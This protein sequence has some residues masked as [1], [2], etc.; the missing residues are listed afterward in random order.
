M[1]I[2]INYDLLDRISE[3]QNGFSLNKCAKRVLYSFCIAST[4]STID[5]AASE[6]NLGRL[7]LIYP[8]H[9]VFLSC[10]TALYTYMFRNVTKNISGQDLDK[11]VL[12]LH[13]INVR[14]NYE[15]LLNAYKYKTEY[16]LNKKDAKPIL[17]QKKYL[18]IPVHDDYFGDREISVIQEHVVGTLKYSLACAEPEQKVYK[19]GA[20]KALQY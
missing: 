11:L 15:S 1:K 2:K 7:L 10:H 14:T 6:N 4:V 12:D 17:V 5:V 13:N 19:L 18:N 20:K 16:K 8:L 9:M 3:A